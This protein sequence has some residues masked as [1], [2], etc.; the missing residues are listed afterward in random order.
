MQKKRIAGMAFRARLMEMDARPRVDMIPATKVVVTNL[1][2]MTRRC[3]Y[4]ADT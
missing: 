4:L 3:P 1:S 2:G